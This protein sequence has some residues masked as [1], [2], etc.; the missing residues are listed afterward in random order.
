MQK[1]MQKTSKAW[2][3]ENGP[4]WNR[5]FTECASSLQDLERQR[6]THRATGS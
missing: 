6:C 4:G 1:R 3:W 2:K 5:T